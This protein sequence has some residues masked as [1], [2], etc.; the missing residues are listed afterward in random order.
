M[1]EYYL[2]GDI[3]FS[4]SFDLSY[5]NEM[6]N[7][8]RKKKTLE[9]EKD[10]MY[11]AILKEDDKNFIIQ[12]IGFNKEGNAGNISYMCRQWNDYIPYFE[13]G[14]YIKVR[15]S[16]VNST[17]IELD[18]SSS[19]LIKTTSGQDCYCCFYVDK[20][21]YSYEQKNKK[22]SIKYYL[23]ETSRNI[24]SEI[25]LD[26]YGGN[27]KCKGL[28]LGGISCVINK[29]SDSL[30][31][32]VRIE[33][34][35]SLLLEDKIKTEFRLLC[36]I[37]S[38]Y[39]NI[40]VEYCTSVK[41]ETNFVNVSRCIPH[42]KV[43]RNAYNNSD[44][45]YLSFGIHRRFINFLMRV[46]KNRKKLKDKLEL[47]HTTISDY[48]RSYDLDEG[49][50]FLVLYSVLETYSKSIKIEEPIPVNE[51]E[52]HHKMENVFNNMYSCF[53]DNLKVEDNDYYK[54]LWDDAKCAFSVKE[55][56]SIVK[57]F[58]YYNIDNDK[59]NI[60]IKKANIKSKKHKI[61]NIS[62]LR[63]RLVHDRKVDNLSKLPM[64]MIN[65][66]LS[67]CVCIVLLYNLGFSN[68]AFHKD[69]ALLSVLNEK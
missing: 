47:L 12:I 6:E 60:E 62:D 30:L 40:P 65:S 5:I 49:S 39:F 33:F 27:E 51:I 11:E 42:Y 55:S 48:V 66:K 10:C 28:T 1:N 53:I 20:Y 16:C 68:I 9:W 36:D 31:L 64:D 41:Y 69:W 37:I 35:N 43:R 56:H 8:E 50:R 3:H 19:R 22:N 13:F 58:D 38:F 59:I 57:L 32:P 26:S 21:K 23:S 45:C 44:L 25:G 2:T 17:F 14:K 29:N 24:I 46:Y 18:L 15:K 54:K 67:F 63:N 61:K 7:G 52:L 34:D 4:F